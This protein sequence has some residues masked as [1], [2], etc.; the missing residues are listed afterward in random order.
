MEFATG[1]S[2]GGMMTY[3]LG[4]SLSHRLAAIA[5][6]SGSMH[7]K[8]VV[9]PQSPIP[10]FAVTGTADTSVPGNGTSN[11][12][13]SDGTWWYT[14]MDKLAELW[15]DAQGGDGVSSQYST[16][17]DGVNDL[18]CKAVHSNIDHVLCSWNGKHNYFGGT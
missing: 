1:Q 15:T 9:T 13:T 3:Q 17:Y 18:W 11:G 4:A 12:K 16:M 7:W 8:N 10:V 5:P 14:S 2:N 6:I